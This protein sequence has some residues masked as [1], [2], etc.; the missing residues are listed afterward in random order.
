[1][2]LHTA[3]AVCSHNC[4]CS[5]TY[6][7]QHFQWLP[8]PL[9]G[10]QGLV[11]TVTPQIFLGNDLL[12]IQQGLQGQ[13]GL[14]SRQSPPIRLDSSQTAPDELVLACFAWCEGR[15]DWRGREG[16]LHRIR[17]LFVN[18][19]YALQDIAAL[20]KTEWIEKGLVVGHQSRLKRC[21]EGFM[22]ERAARR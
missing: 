20:A 18:E 1:V 14:Q 9:G 4:S 6:F 16:E 22:S 15:P 12:G 10:Q 5:N 21:I 8:P 11:I 19:D 17:D 2:Q 3:I 13:Q 7:Y